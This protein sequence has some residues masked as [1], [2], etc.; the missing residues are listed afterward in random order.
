MRALLLAVRFGSELALL[1]AL[2]VIGANVAAGLLAVVGAVVLP[3]LAAWVW[4]R[5]VA[6]RSRTRA[7]DPSRAAVEAVLFG[8]A[9]IGLVAVHHAVAAAVL[10]AVGVTGAVGSRWA[11]GVAGPDGPA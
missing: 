2:A 7:S 10:A 6:P 9:V 11:D 1:V 8:V 5:L 4:A 3:A